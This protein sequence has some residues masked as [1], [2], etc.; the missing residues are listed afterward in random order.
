MDTP[1]RE[2]NLLKMFASRVKRLKLFLPIN[3]LKEL[4]NPNIL[5]FLYFFISPMPKIVHLHSRQSVAKIM[6]VSAAEYNLEHTKMQKKVFVCAF[7][8]MY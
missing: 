5:K 3:I 8:S 2:A 4:E 1:S 6:Q 7:V